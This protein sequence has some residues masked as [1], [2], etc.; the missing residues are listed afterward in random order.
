MVWRKNNNAIRSKITVILFIY[1]VD[2]QENEGPGHDLALESENT[3]NDPVLA[4]E[5]ERENHHGRIQVK[6]E[7]ERGRKNAKKRDC[8]PSDQKPW[9]VS[10]LLRS[11]FRLSVGN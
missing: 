11:D 2:H 6:E 8:L 10:N 9:V 1:L 4:Q 5:N 3:G 7:P